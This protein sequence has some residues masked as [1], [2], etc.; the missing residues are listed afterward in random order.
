MNYDIEVDINTIYDFS[1]DILREGDVLLEKIN[2]FLE[3]VE[4]IEECYDTETGK[5]LKEKLI[6]LVNKDKKMINDKYLSFSKTMKNVADI[7]LETK[8]RINKSV[9]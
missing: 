9:Q 3:Q 5:I 4:K 7:Y 1:N 6:E 2:K 8:D